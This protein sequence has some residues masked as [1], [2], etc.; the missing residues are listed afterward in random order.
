MHT[1]ARY[2][3]TCTPHDQN[4]ASF[5]DSLLS[6]GRGQASTSQNEC[7]PSM[8]PPRFATQSGVGT[9]TFNFTCTCICVDCCLTVVCSAVACTGPAIMQGRRPSVQRLDM[10]DY[11]Y[12]PTSC[13]L[14]PSRPK[15]GSDGLGQRFK[16]LLALAQA[17]CTCPAERT[18]TSLVQVASRVW[19]LHI[20]IGGQLIRLV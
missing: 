8:H 6:V 7:R 18:C 3:Y 5:V 11:R 2:I 9:L 4:V 10:H 17:L 15:T 20:L 16:C 12:V 13:V 1:P 19:V 14:S